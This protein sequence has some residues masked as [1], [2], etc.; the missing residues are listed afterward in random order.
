MRALF[1][2]GYVPVFAVWCVVL[3]REGFEPR[4]PCIPR[5]HGQCDGDEG[6]DSMRRRRFLRC[7]GLVGAGLAMSPGL[8]CA[9]VSGRGERTAASERISIGLLGM[10]KMCNGHLGGLLNTGDVQVVAVSDVESGRLQRACE[11]IDS[12]YADQAGTASYRSAEGYSDY[13]DLLARP[14]IDAVVIASPTNWHAAMAVHACQAGK[15]VYC[16]KPLAL[17]VHE[18]RAIAAAADRAGAIFQTGSQQ[19]SDDTF[20]LAC[21]LVRNGRIGRVHTVRVNIGGPP[22]DCYLPAVATPETLDW[23]RWL[24]PAPYR[25]YHPELCPLDRYESW[26]RWRYY[27]DYGG[28]GMTD[29]GAHHFDIAQWALGRDHTGPVEILPPGHGDGDRLTYRYEDGVVMTRGGAMGG[30][31]VEFIGA[32]G[33]VAVNRSGFLHT[34][35]EDLRHTSFGPGETRLYR[36]R[37]GHRNDWLRCIRERTRP[38]CPAE[39]GCRSVTVCHLGNIAYLLQRPLRWDPGKERFADDAAADRLLRRPMRAPWQV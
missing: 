27:R 32:D 4:T 1:R 13:R 11:R 31:A 24:G 35:P 8:V 16:E 2:V 17:T 22:D 29:F 37:G 12:H 30:A 36:S 39:I 3:R 10:G 38:V 26:P 21:E 34:E 23:D 28:G 19:R 9:A 25:P 20:R 6:K 18:A 14:D 33:R 5:R 7:S 15:D